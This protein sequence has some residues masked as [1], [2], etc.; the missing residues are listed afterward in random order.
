MRSTSQ[1][2]SGL[3][4]EKFA[5]FRIG[6]QKIA[7]RRADVDRKRKV[8]NLL[9]SIADVL[10]GDGGRWAGVHGCCLVFRWLMLAGQC[11]GALNVAG[12]YNL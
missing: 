3:Q 7:G 6:E 2:L 11:F 12:F 5:G 1:V 8:A 9:K 10:P 4:A